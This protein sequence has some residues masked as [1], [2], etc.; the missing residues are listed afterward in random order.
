M[1]GTDSFQ[2]STEGGLKKYVK[3]KAQ[4]YHSFIYTRSSCLA[5]EHNIHR[6]NSR[7][8]ESLRSTELL[9]LAEA[10]YVRDPLWML[11]Q[12]V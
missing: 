3:R 8:T 10:R 7:D 4:I 9:H 6:H 12:N 2:I 1:P 5:L 11:F